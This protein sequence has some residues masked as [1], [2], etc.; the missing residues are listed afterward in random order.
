MVVLGHIRCGDSMEKH[1]HAGSRG[2]FITENQKVDILR[3]HVDISVAYRGHANT[4]TTACL[5]ELTNQN[6]NNNLVSGT[7]H[8]TMTM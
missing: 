6:R 4:N 1:W 2:V 5:Q 3:G 7:G 8:R